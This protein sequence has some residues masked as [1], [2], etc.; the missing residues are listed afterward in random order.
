MG[1]DNDDYTSSP[2]YAAAWHAGAKITRSYGGL[3]GALRSMAANV[4]VSDTFLDQLDACHEAYKKYVHLE[5]G[6]YQSESRLK[7]RKRDRQLASAAAKLADEQM[8]LKAL[9][10]A[11]QV[12]GAKPDAT[13]EE[14]RKFLAGLDEHMVGAV[15]GS[16][17]GFWS[18]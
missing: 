4:G 1:N 11:D 7:K 18:P 9:S 16:R 2:E 17:L 13:D 5:L 15:E 14:A 6:G 10:T 12:L 3:S 8:Q